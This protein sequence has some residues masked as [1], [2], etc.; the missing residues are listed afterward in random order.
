MSEEFAIFLNCGH[1]ELHDEHLWFFKGSEYCCIG[2]EY[3]FDD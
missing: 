2:W 3:E 1:G